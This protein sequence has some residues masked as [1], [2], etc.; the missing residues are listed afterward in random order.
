MALYAKRADKSHRVY[1][2][3]GDGESNEGQIWEA[4]LFAAHHHLD[5]LTVI[6]DYNKLQIDGFTR[7]I[8]DLEPFADKWR[9]FGWETFEMDGH[10]WDSI[11]E[12]IVRAGSVQGKPAMIIAHTIKGRGICEM[13]NRA[14]SHNVKIADQAAYDRIM[15]A[16]GCKFDLPY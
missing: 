15:C 9:A 2:I 11:Y 14:E 5:N 1:C 8:L 7:D 4:A 3:I 6:C 10:D 13:E 16:L 12:T